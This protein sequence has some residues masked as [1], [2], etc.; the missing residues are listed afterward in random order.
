MGRVRIV[1]R[2]RA[3]VDGQQAGAQQPRCGGP[4]SRQPRASGCHA[5]P[6]RSLILACLVR[7]ATE[8]VLQ[9]QPPG[10][11]LGQVAL[12][13]GRWAAL[14]AGPRRQTRVDGLVGQVTGVQGRH[15]GERAKALE[16]DYV[17]RRIRD[18][19]LSA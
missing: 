11:L 19:A 17:R 6:Y 1:K 8:K 7:R 16:R 13:G 3:E 2:R 15:G 5:A 18:L 10:A 14:L 9:E 12:K 4:D